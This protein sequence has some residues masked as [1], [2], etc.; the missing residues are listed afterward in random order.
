MRGTIAI[1]TNSDQ[2]FVEET[3]RKDERF[4]PHLDGKTTIKVIWV[5][6]KLINFVVR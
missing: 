4:A 2:A 1:P 6:N 3:V 5:P